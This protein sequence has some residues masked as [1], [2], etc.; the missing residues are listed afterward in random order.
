M[1]QI[2]HLVGIVFDPWHQCR[3]D[4]LAPQRSSVSARHL[5]FANHG[6][7]APMLVFSEVALGNVPGAEPELRQVVLVDEHHGGAESDQV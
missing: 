4:V 6:V 3:A 1:Q 7:D 5:V 2:Y